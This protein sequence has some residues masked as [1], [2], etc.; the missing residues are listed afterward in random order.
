MTSFSIQLREVRLGEPSSSYIPAWA[1]FDYAARNPSVDHDI[2]AEAND[3]LGAAPTAWLE[4]EARAPWR[5]VR[6]HHRPRGP[7]QVVIERLLIF[8]VATDAERFAWKFHTRLDELELADIERELHRDLEH[9]LQGVQSGAYA[10]RGR[11]MLSGL[12]TMKT[13]QRAL[14]RLA[15]SLER[16]KKIRSRLGLGQG[17]SLN[18]LRQFRS[19]ALEVEQDRAERALPTG[20]TDEPVE[21][22]YRRTAEA[23]RQSVQTGRYDLVDL[24]R[25]QWAARI[26]EVKA[27]ANL[28]RRL[29][30]QRCRAAAAAEGRPV[31]TGRPGW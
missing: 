21:Q 5:L 3:L 14:Q 1:A 22:V 27:W 15:E 8:E 20:E 18:W 11:S 17:R 6:R 13:L 9:L 16:A 10:V 23:L 25:R 28:V 29:H 24:D 31:P 19:A 26:T 7:R 30:R 4:S 2:S 12:E